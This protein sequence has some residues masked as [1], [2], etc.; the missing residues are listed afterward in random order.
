MNIL[1]LTSILISNSLGL[2]S[3]L[4]SQSV[5]YHSISSKA[6][7]LTLCPFYWL[8]HYVHWIYIF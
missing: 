8:T 2:P 5:F 1:Y 6:M 4:M 3:F 7:L